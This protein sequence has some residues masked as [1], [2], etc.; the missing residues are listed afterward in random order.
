M[1]LC[2][3]QRVGY[4]DSKRLNT[5]HTAKAVPEFHRIS[6]NRSKIRPRL[7]ILLVFSLTPVYY[8][9]GVCQGLFT[10]LPIIFFDLLLFTP[11][12]VTSIFLTTIRF[13][14]KYNTGIHSDP[15]HFTQ[16]NLLYQ[17][18]VLS[19]S[20]PI[21]SCSK[22]TATLQYRFREWFPSMINSHV[23]L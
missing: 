14:L 21:P 8:P 2:P 15:G 22:K 10:I 16:I 12:T 17:P 11:F 4:A 23:S 1:S 3:I 9:G 19:F 5:S 18:S 7:V 13:P 20:N 6:L